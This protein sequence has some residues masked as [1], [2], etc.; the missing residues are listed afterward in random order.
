M[1]RETFEEIWERANPG[2]KAIRDR[3]LNRSFD[4]IWGEAREYTPR[5]KLIP[6]APPEIVPQILAT[7]PEQKVEAIISEFPDFLL[8][9]R[10]QRG[11]EEEIRAYLLQ[12][13]YTDQG[14]TYM[15]K[16]QTR[17]R[18]V[19]GVR[20]DLLRF[21]LQEAGLFI[22]TMSVRERTPDD[23]QDMLLDSYA[24][25]LEMVLRASTV[26]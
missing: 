15:G 12:I 26:S 2:S 7:P 17:L 24:S 18:G 25:S 10:V 22:R 5:R 6:K 3:M 1:S 13:G 20:E 11:S 8:P 9:A 14:I 16:L 19:V 4:E 21:S 23:L